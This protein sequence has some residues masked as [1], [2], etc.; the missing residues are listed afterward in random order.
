M[1]KVLLISALLSLA[2]LAMS[3]T[4]R[5][6]YEQWKKLQQEN[7]NSYKNDRRSQYED[8]R[9]KANKEYA[10]FIRKG[11]EAMPVE[12]AIPLP[13]K[14]KPAHPIEVPPDKIPSADLI[15]PD[16]V[17]VKYQPQELVLPPL[18]TLDNPEYDDRSICELSFVFYGTPCKVAMDCGS[19]FQLK[20]FSGESLAA[21]WELLSNRNL[22]IAL[23]DIID[24][25]K[26][27]LLNDWG[28]IDL[29]CKTAE[30]FMGGRCH[31]SVFLSDYLLSQLG[32]QSTLA[33]S[34]KGLY[35]LVAF[36]DMVYNYEYVNIKGTNYY[37]LDKTQ[38][39]SFSVLRE[40]FPETKKVDVRLRQVPNLNI[41]KTDGR[42]F[43]AKLYPGLR[44]T[45]REN[46][47]LIDFW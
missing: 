6:N 9:T 19:M 5:D 13:K 37:L 7:Y 22:D 44:V 16:D 39:N 47:N 29:V 21:A 15:V 2:S 1:K 17:V 38:N 40:S 28:I 12:P 26:I 10:Q 43:A 18:P 27:L 25:S 34:D 11:W 31:E 3:Q 14:P 33:K 4:D 32:T 45:I 46:K 36:S 35:L 23:K 41:E 20:D 42:T 24:L 30:A 8:F